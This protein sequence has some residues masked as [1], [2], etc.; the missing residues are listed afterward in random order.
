M[1]IFFEDKLF[2]ICKMFEF[3]LKVF[4]EDIIF[5]ILK[6][7]YERCTFYVVKMCGKFRNISLA[8]LYLSNF[9]KIM[10]KC[11]KTSSLCI[12][13]LILKGIMF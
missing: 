6:K 8:F 12:T 11:G 10:G 13:C 4:L 3:K 7:V 9:F 2:K 1:K 5:K